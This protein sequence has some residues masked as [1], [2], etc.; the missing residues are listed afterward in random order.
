MEWSEVEIHTLNEAV[1]AVANQLTEYGASGVSITDASDFHRERE[2]KFGEIYA[3]SAA[4][5][6]DNGVVIKAYFL[7]TDEFIAQL[8]DM[9]QAIRDLKQFDIPLG[10]LS[11]H[12]NDVDDDDWATAWKKYYHPVQITE[13]VTVS[14]T[15]E[16]YVGSQDE[17]VIELDPGMA[18]G[19]GTH[20]T[21]QLCMRALET[22]L[23]E[24]D[25]VI[26]VGTGSGVLSILCAKLGAKEVLAMDLD[27]VA[28]RA[29]Q[30][31]IN[32]NQVDAIVTLKQNNLLEGLNERV[33]LIVANILAEVILL[34]P[35]DVYQTLKPGG[36]FIASGII[37]E[38]AEVV[39]EAIVNAGMT[40]V[41][42]ETQ[43]D[44]VAIIAKRG[45][46]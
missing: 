38:K 4:D 42:T 33:D 32:Q 40:I 21:T 24:D 36:T 17:I 27:E 41:Q 16:N 28:V 44:W 2:D 12:V 3:L 37:A 15:W 23:Q 5:Y 19:T 8:P 34:F 20:P 39:R 11:F 18:F 6:P 22:Y 45:E 1:E 43:G 9:E 26:D 10:E 31:N 13:K 35:E 7:K 14:P 25:T 30:E 46:A 29:A